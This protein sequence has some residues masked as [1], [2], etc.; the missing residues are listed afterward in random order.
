MLIEVEKLVVRGWR[1]SQTE[2]EG[3]DG[4]NDEG[5]LRE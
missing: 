5:D 1:D 2:S 4:K 3:T